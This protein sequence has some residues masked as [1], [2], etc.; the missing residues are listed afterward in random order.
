MRH[1]D[2]PV[3]FVTVADCANSDPAVVKSGRIRKSVA[4]AI[5]KEVKALCGL[6][7]SSVATEDG[8]S[9]LSENEQHSCDEFSAIENLRELSSKK[10]K[11]KR[12]RENNAVAETGANYPIDIWLLLASYIRPEDVMNFALIC[13]N[14][15][16]VTCTAA[17]WIRL[18]KR[19]YKMNVYLPVRLL[20]ECMYKLHCLRACV[21]RSLYHMYEPFCSLV[22]KSPPIPELTPDT[23]ANSKCLLFWYKKAGGN[24]S[25]NM[26][27]F[28]FKFKKQHPKL[29]NHSL[30]ELQPPSKYKEVHFNP[31]NDCYLLQVSTLNFI[32]IPIVMGMTLAYFTIN[33]ST[34]MRHHRVRLVF[35][36]SPVWNGK[37]PRGDQGVQIVLDPVHTVHLLDWWHPKY[38]FSSRA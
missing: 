6:E 31:D 24:R 7:A 10:K 32:F 17:F 36:D 19:Y 35:Q 16:I 15:W 20:P 4:N 1:W 29:K 37:K 2:A 9:I 28:N 8:H 22:A 33:V 30:K 14:A 26:W 21:I 23:L 5:Q 27:E 13:K 25:E 11:S 18:Y 38:P 3:V 34:D 12:H